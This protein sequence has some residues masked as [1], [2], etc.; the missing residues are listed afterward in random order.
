MNAL[1]LSLCLSAAPPLPAWALKEETVAAQL[2]DSKLM[3]SLAAP[4]D[5]QG[6]P[7]SAEELRALVKKLKPTID[8][9]SSNGLVKLPTNV[10]AKELLGMATPPPPASASKKKSM[11]DLMSG[12]SAVNAGAAFLRLHE[13]E[14]KEAAAGTAVKPVDIVALFA[15]QSDFGNSTG[16][17]L[18]FNVF[19][20]EVVFL[21]AAYEAALQRGHTD[22]EGR[23]K[24]EK[25]EK[26]KNDAVAKLSALLRYAKLHKKDALT[27]KGSWAGGVGA[28]QFTP[29]QFQYMT[30]SQFYNTGGEMDAAA[31][32]AR[33]LADNGYAKDRK[34][35]FHAYN[36]GDEWVAGVIKYADALKKYGP[37]VLCTVRTNGLTNFKTSLPVSE[38]NVAAELFEY[39][40]ANY[41][42]PIACDHNVIIG[43]TYMDG[44]GLN[45]AGE[46][47]AN[48]LYFKDGVEIR[49]A[50]GVDVASVSITAPRG[51]K[52]PKA[53]KAAMAKYARQASV[54]SAS[55]EE[56]N[57]VTCEEEDGRLMSLTY[58][59]IH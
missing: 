47:P 52:K 19:L 35:A 44:P 38:L 56:D 37:A 39:A 32:L 59:E 40:K 11:S 8:A 18:L 51:L 54:C 25:L 13:A 22:D 24:A 3:K 31:S 50:I 53:A 57:L 45:T 46:M 16:E 20:G 58:Q 49:D 9:P 48:T 30:D 1:V 42:A 4:A 43:E 6:E 21:D 33:F 27:I 2:A 17:Y 10:Y 26:F 23:F 29:L 36:P 5:E 55:T 15:W 14:L 7:V 34:G 12:R 28:A 41:G